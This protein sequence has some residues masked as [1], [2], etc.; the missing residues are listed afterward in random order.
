[1]DA[2]EVRLLADRAVQSSVN[3]IVI[4]DAQQPDN[5]VIYVNPGFEQITGFS[6]REAIG[7]NCRFLQGDDRD[8]PALNELRAAIREGRECQVM[9]RNYKKDGTPFWNELFV[10]PVHDEEG[11]LISFVG[12]QNDVTE[13]RRLGEELRKSEARLRLAIESA[14]LGTWDFNPVTGELRWDA[15]C[16]ALFGLPPEAEVDYEVFLQ[17]LH[18]EDRERTDRIVQRT[19]DPAS[20]GA[21]DIEYRTI[22][23]EDGAERWVAARG[24]AFFD[25]AG[26]AVRFLGTVLDIT[27]RRLAEDELRFQ[28]VLLEAQSETSIDGILFVSP[29]GRIISFNRRYAEMWRIPE[30]VMALRSSEATLQAIRDKLVDP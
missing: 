23:I 6:G 19:L 15:Q 28:K 18:P 14:G 3:G 7:K 22:G 4:A 16:K 24:Q 8:Q 21:Y 10:S 9:L 17:G 30:G 5:P 13:R 20:G 1:L 12:V 26:R 25:E 27:E 2:Q 29:Q 11:R